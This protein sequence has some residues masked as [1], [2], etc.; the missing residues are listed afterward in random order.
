MARTPDD[1]WKFHTLVASYVMPTRKLCEA[2]LRTPMDKAAILSSIAKIQ[3]E[4]KLRN[5]RRY[6]AFGAAYV[7]ANQT[8][9]FQLNPLFANWH[10]RFVRDADAF[11][12]RL[13]ELG[14]HEAK[15]FD[16][17]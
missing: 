17:K 10:H 11:H 14:P 5:P 2:L 3:P 8:A 7:A 12:Q 9:D 4:S 15:S 6:Y 13:H 16:F 1:L